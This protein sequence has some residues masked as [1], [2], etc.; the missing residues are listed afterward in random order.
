MMASAVAGVAP[1]LSP[2]RGRDYLSSADFSAA[3]TFFSILR[4]NSSEATVASIWATELGLIFT[5]ASTRT[6]VVSMWPWH[7]WVVKRLIS[8][9]LTQVGRG[10]RSD[11]ARVLSRYCDVLAIRTLLSGSC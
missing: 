3:E 2:L 10:S 8:I 1:A 4:L 9:A 6:R 7:V 11:T 5:K